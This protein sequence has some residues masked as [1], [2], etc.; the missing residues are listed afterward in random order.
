MHDDKAISRLSRNEQYWISNFKWDIAAECKCFGD[1]PPLMGC[2]TIPQ[3]LVSIQEFG[4]VNWPGA[5]V[6]SF[7]DD[8]K[9]DGANG[10]WRNTERF[11]RALLKLRMGMLTPDYSTFG[12]AHPEIC[13]WN[14]FRSRIVGF[15][16]EKR[17]VPVIPTLIW[18]DDESADDASLGLREGQVYAVTTINVVGNHEKRR[19]FGERV[20]R[21]CSAL[22][23]KALLVY[24]SPNGID[25]GGVSIHAFPNGTYDWTHLHGELP[26]S[27]LQ[28]P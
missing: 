14:R 28:V 16:M 4:K 9:F 24:G 1:L 17:R 12:D 23:P 3:C 11:I 27:A 26:V 2:G 22:D 18:W 15:H 20:R 7:K 8:Y 25:W 13:R 6:H 21:I 10:L 19:L 5:F